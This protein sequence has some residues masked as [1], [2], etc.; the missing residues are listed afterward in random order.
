MSPSFTSTP[1]H[2]ASST[3]G[4]GTRPE[5]GE[6][7]LSETSSLVW[8]MQ[9]SEVETARK[10]EVSTSLTLFFSLKQK[11][12]FVLEV[13]SPDVLRVGGRQDVLPRPIITV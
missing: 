9:H 1:E 10:Q 8:V 2:G 6:S 3:T 5:M 11:L 13:S 7:A 12:V 4:Q